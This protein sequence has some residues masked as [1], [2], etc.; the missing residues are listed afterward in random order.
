MFEIHLLGTPHFRLDGKPYRFIARPKALPLLA[1]LLL[2]RAHPT[3]R[4]TL[5]FTLWPDETEAT[6]HAN[7]RRHLHELARALPQMPANLPW[8]LIDSTTVQW[9][10]QTAY[11]LD[12][13]QFEKLSAAEETLA[14]AVALYGGDLVEDV[15]DDCL[16]ADRERLRD[17]SFSD[18]WRLVALK[19]AQRDLHAAI[20]YV[21]WLLSRDAFRED[22]VRQ[23]IS[24]RYEAGD[25]AGAL[26]EFERFS[27]HLRE[28]M[29]VEPMPETV[30]LHEVIARNGR[31]ATTVPI[32]ETRRGEE[33][34]RLTLPFVGRE[35]EMEQL[36]TQWSRAARGRGG[37]VL[38]GGEAG[39][40]KTRMANE[41]SLVAEREGARVLYG[42]ATFAESIPY[43]VLAEALRPAA[44]LM[45][46]MEIDAIWL[47]AVAPLVPELRT[48]RPQLP[49]LPPLDAEHERARLFES[50]SRCV[51]GLAQPRPLLL[52]LDDLQWASSTT[53]SLLEY[54]ARRAPLHALLILATYR[55]EQMPRAHP[56][57]EF[58]H[59]LARERLLAHRTL[60][61]LS[62]RA[63]GILVKQVSGLK[64]T[65][66]GNTLARQL[67]MESEGNPF[68]L[69]ESIRDRL[70][71]GGGTGH[72]TPTSVQQVILS[73][74]ARLSTTARALAEIAAIVGNAFD[75]EVV[76]QVSGWSEAEVLD[77]LDELLDH[78]L[79]REGAGRTRADYLFN[80]HL[81]QAAIY[82]TVPENARK[83]RHHRVA[84]VLE[85][86]DP[87]RLDEIAGDLAVHFEHA[88][89]WPEAIRYYRAAGD[90]AA[91]VFAYARSLDLYAHSLDLL[92]RLGANSDELD[93]ERL[94][95]LIH[96]QRI[97]GLLLRV[98]A[99]E[100]DI[101]EIQ[102]LASARQDPAAL[103]QAL[104]ARLSIHVYH[105]NMAAFEATA[106]RALSLAREVE[107]GAAEARIALWLGRHLLMHL[108]L[109][110]RAK[111]HLQRALTLAESQSDNTLSFSVA[112]DLAQTERQLGH[113]TIAR[114]VARRA[115]KLAETNTEL[116]P[117]RGEAFFQLGCIAY[118]RAEWESA[119]T[120][121]ETAV[122]LLSTAQNVL[123]LGEALVIL[124]QIMAQLGQFELA[125]RTYETLTH[126]IQQTEIPNQGD[127]VMWIKCTA[128]GDYAFLGDIE[129]A[130]RFA[131]EL[132]EWMERTY[133]AP[134][135][136][137]FSA[138]GQLR[139][140][141]HRDQEAA[142]A[143]ARAVQ[144]WGGRWADLRPLLLH[145]LAAQRFGDQEQA[146]AGLARAE[147]VRKT[148]ETARFNVLLYYTRFEILGNVADLQQARMELQR[149]ASLIQDEKLRSDFLER[150][151][152][153]HEIEVRWQS[154][155]GQQ[156][157]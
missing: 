41:L 87:Q 66:G 69:A 13:A 125:K 111:P 156:D 20:R 119:R 39:I 96:R 9:N 82:D 34:T 1:Y 52:I 134:Q 105:G 129:N 86:L 95:L 53:F 45:A 19:R 146:K 22:A 115:L 72:A 130:E 97:L 10:P 48:L 157:R 114:E 135:I 84:H 28:E 47:S 33:K 60:T 85:G 63:V 122:Q 93:A 142:L 99:W 17:L 71:S 16:L 107:D 55:E 143:L 58:R 4:D 25:R 70:E 56:L 40:G 64:S 92:N 14:E 30:A 37:L 65:N 29:N 132:Q 103:L 8:V 123:V 59:R 77:G 145:A 31:L 24:L 138:L 153:H 49:A 91:K 118:D 18:L 76:S 110:V 46:V 133:A 78:Q 116:T 6:A 35:V 27:Q 127:M 98:R 112:C 11:W 5:A 141:Q 140:A 7:L 36:R 75:V 109:P 12:V 21:Q 101:D 106:G 154:A 144:V 100:R 32:I 2:H 94:G 42:G 26:H 151:P 3:S 113:L 57:R 79:I 102:R 15:Y 152:L 68:F 148:I 137:A 117:V 124:A 43:Q 89:A 50:I 61:R 139:L 80:H 104:E 88:E 54:I 128:M 126:L 155:L 136:Q 62:E 23:L 121:M 149:Q 67:Y 120:N 147:A 108:S 131:I 90:H 83:R 74:V 38:I 51:E 44:R 81:V 150:V 73:R